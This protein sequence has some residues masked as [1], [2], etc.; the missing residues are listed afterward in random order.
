MKNK[1][2]IIKKKEFD[3]AMQSLIVKLSILCQFEENA[4]SHKFFEL[5]HRTLGLAFQLFFTQV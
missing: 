1:R 5:F 4:S 3:L 2:E